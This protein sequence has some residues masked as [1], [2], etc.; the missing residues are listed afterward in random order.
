MDVAG[1]FPMDRDALL[2]EIKELK[3]EVKSLKDEKKNTVK[4]MVTNLINHRISKIT[5]KVVDTWKS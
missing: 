5:S 3:E 1:T 4:E 2:L